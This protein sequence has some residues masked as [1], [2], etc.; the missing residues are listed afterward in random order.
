MTFSTTQPAVQFYTGNFLDDDR[1][2]NGKNGL[3]YPRRGG[4]C[5]ETQRY[6]CAPNFPD[7]PG[8][9]LRP[10]EEYREVTEY[11]FGVR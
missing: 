3:R 4:F 8:A 7:F 6:P 9:V 5:L 1:A 11:R 2:P 10:G